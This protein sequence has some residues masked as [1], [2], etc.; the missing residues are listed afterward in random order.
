MERPSDTPFFVEKNAN[1]RHGLR[2][3]H[4]S[5]EEPLDQVT[6]RKTADGQIREGIIVRFLE[7][8]GLDSIDSGN[9]TVDPYQLEEKFAKFIRVQRR[10]APRGLK[11]I[12]ESVTFPVVAHHCKIYAR[13]CRREIRELPPDA[14]Q[15]LRDSVF[16]K[17][18]LSAQI[19][20]IVQEAVSMTVSQKAASRNIFIVQPD[21]SPDEV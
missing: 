3:V 14:P 17:A 21:E 8:S 12:V 16:P 2:L 15:E 18:R 9:N 10:V 20:H 11:E 19:N 4:G 7:E 6:R 1:R 5:G 13:R